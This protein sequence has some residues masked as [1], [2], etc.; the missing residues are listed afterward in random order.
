MSNASL[1]SAL[2]F[3]SPGCP[4]CPGI[5]QALSLLQQEAAIGALDVVDV[6]R[7]PARAQVLDVRSVPW[8]RIGD[9]QFE[10]QMSLGELR[11]WAQRAA[12]PQGITHYCHDMLKSGR[13]DKVERLIRDRPTYAQLLAE[14]A[15]DAEAGMET[16]LGV[17][18][19]LEELRGTGLTTPMVPV[20]AQHLAD[21]DPRQR[22]DAAHFLSLVGGEAALR[23][24]QP[25]VDD[26][27]PEVREI[28]RE[29]LGMA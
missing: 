29:A 20:L 1:P 26:A 25:Y 19:V 11:E 8:F 14:L 21:V 13:R 5:K 24:L 3:T 27:D 6:S 4:Y 16:R 10:G 7:D 18:A 15:F 17:G 22:A 2:L 23:V 12:S 9:L 28:A